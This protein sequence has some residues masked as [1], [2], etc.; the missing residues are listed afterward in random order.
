MCKKMVSLFVNNVQV[1][2]IRGVVFSRYQKH[3]EALK[4]WPESDQ[5]S[6][7]EQAAGR[8]YHMAVCSF[9][10]RTNPASGNV[11]YFLSLVSGQLIWICN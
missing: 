11:K 7:A 3:M 10:T 5:F 9:S 6:C 2:T 4:N 1:T 8:G